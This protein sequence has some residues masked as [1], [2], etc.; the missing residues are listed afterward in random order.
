MSWAGTMSWHMIPASDKGVQVFSDEQLH[1]TSPISPNAML[2]HCLSLFKKLPM[3]NTY[4][5]KKTYPHC[6]CLD[7]PSK[8]SLNF[9][10]L[11]K[12]TWLSTSNISICSTF[13]ELNLCFYLTIQK[14]D[15]NELLQP[16]LTPFSTGTRTNTFITT[17]TASLLLM[18]LYNSF[19]EFWPSQP[20]LSIFFY[21][22][23]ES[24]SLV[25]LTSVYLF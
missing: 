20:T 16:P 14:P 23:Q 1:V 4:V 17:T 21:L 22:G 13:G 3:N 12:D 10:C 5:I 18:W 19:I 11:S 7:L 15:V 6:C 8:Y 2:V 9:W 25:L 24:S